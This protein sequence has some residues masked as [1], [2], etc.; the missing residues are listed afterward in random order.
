MELSTTGYYYTQEHTWAQAVQTLEFVLA[1]VQSMHMCG[2]TTYSTTKVC[3]RMAPFITSACT[4]SFTLMRRECGSVHTKP[5]STSFTCKGSPGRTQHW[6]QTMC[7]AKTCRSQVSRSHRG[8]KPK[9][10]QA[11]GLP[12][13]VSSNTLDSG[14]ESCDGCII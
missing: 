14:L 3:C 12:W 4:V 13:N 8:E 6:L 1:R 5:A 9:T 7:E 2:S 11:G 10:G